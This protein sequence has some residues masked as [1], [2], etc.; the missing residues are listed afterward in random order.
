M[1]PPRRLAP[2]RAPGTRDLIG[3]GGRPPVVQWPGH[4]AAMG[5]EVWV[6]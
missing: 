6:S 4:L 3:Y 5:S 1:N 2:P